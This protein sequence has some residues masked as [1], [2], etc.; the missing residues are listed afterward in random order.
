MKGESCLYRLGQEAERKEAETGGGGS[1]AEVQPPRQGGIFLCPSLKLKQIK[2]GK[3]G[4]NLTG[5]CL[6][7]T[8][9]VFRSG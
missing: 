2:K 1:G 4:R 9:E 8:L 5:S 6:F 3:K 7:S